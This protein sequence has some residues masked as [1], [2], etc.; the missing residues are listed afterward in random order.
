MKAEEICGLP[1]N[2]STSLTRNHFN[3]LQWTLSISQQHVVNKPDALLSKYRISIRLRK[4]E[5]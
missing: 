4:C 5:I 2:L 3:Y 1:K